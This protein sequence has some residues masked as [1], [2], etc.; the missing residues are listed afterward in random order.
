MTAVAQVVKQAG[1]VGV[2]ADEV[3]FAGRQPM[4]PNHPERQVYPSQCRDSG[5]IGA[6][7]QHHYRRRD[8]TALRKYAADASAHNDCVSPRWPIQIVPVA[9]RMWLQFGQL[10][11]SFGVLYLDSFAT[12]FDRPQR[13]ELIQR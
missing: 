8:G 1:D 5:R 2:R 4:A 7:C 3:V 13:L 10:C 11:Q 9:S 12:D 6:G